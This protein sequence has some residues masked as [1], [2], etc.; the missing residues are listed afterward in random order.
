MTNDIRDE[1]VS[2]EIDGRGPVV[3]LLPTIPDAAPY[4]VRE[5]IARQR[6]AAV[7]GEC[8]CGAQADYNAARVDG[9]NVAE[10]MHDRRCPADTDRLAKAIRRWAR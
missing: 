7:T 3:A 10:V 9:M 6:I 4:R 2:F 1:L 5:G 8:P